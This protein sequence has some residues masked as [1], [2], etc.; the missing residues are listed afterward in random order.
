MITAP[1]D[2]YEDF[3][4][5][6]RVFFFILFFV[7][8]F[9]CFYIPLEIE[10]GWWHLSTARWMVENQD[11]PHE[12][13]FSYSETKAP[14][15]YTQWLGGLI[16][17]FVHRIG[18]ND[19]LKIFRALFFTL[20]IFLFVT[21]AYKKIPLAILILLA[22]ILVHG[23]F[24]R[25]LIRPLIFNFIFIPL[26]LVN[27]FGYLKTSNPR[28]LF[29]L[30]L[31]GILW[32]NIHLGSFVY[33]LFPIL[34]VLLARTVEYFYAR[35]SKKIQNNSPFL[36][37][38]VKGLSLAFLAYCFIFLLN[39]YGLEGAIHPLKVFLLPDFIKFYDL[40]KVI[41]E[42]QSPLL[43]LRTMSGIPFIVLFLLTV[44]SLIF[45][46]RDRLVLGLLFVFSLFIFSQGIQGVAFYVIVGV[47]IVLECLAQN[48]GLK[49]WQ[50]S[51]TSRRFEFSLTLVMMITLSVRIIFMIQQD[52]AFKNGE[53]VRPNPLVALEFLK[54]EKM[55]G[56]VY[57]DEKF[58][59]YIIWSSYPELKPFWDGRQVQPERFIKYYIDTMEDPAANWP[60]VENEY[61]F[62]IVLL[63]KTAKIFSRLIEYLENHSS[64]ELIFED[65]SCVVFK[66]T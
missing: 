12:D 32:V 36:A 50:S 35:P 56:P 8:L 40:K 44:G 58:G 16:F 9:L 13:V 65:D 10:D 34:I 42:M 49:S 62:K 39:P 33:G 26:F 29:V 53:Y 2:A 61:R 7:F 22:L 64:W 24:P 51:P 11:V 17:Y 6:M 28:R 5:I 4:K 23:L 27:I 52:G 60:R 19:G 14:W 63:D 55:E 21:R 46:K 20:T 57:N 31:L 38:Q 54:K 45:H 66:K 41:E 15:I 1:K 3:S 30:L 37:K 18:D 59:G 25:C 47:Y 43:V 48:A